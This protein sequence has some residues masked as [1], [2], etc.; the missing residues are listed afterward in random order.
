MQKIQTK[1]GFG[2]YVDSAG[3][4][5]L[6]A[7]L[8]IGE[9]PLSDDFT[10]VEVANKKALDAIELYIDPAQIEREKNEQK[11]SAKIRRIAIDALIAEG[12]LPGDH[13]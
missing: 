8:P 13:E 10:Y 4:R 9:H 2:Y 12:Q 1:T 6:K 7:E 5:I 11:I 3:H